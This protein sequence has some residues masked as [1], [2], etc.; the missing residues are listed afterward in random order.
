LASEL[1]TT[2]PRNDFDALGDSAVVGV[3]SE[4]PPPD[5]A[6]IGLARVLM[7]GESAAASI[8]LTRVL[9]GGESALPPLLLPSGDSRPAGDPLTFLCRRK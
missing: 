6:S 5:A 4:S 1:L 8:G 9:M 2:I 3:S 7:G